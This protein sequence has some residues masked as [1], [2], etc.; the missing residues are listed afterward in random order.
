MSS[1]GRA[2]S[3]VVNGFKRPGVHLTS[4]T[5]TRKN[6]F[7][8]FEVDTE[9]LQLFN[10]NVD[11][12]IKTFKAKNLKPIMD[13]NAERIIVPRVQAN[14]TNAQSYDRWYTY[15]G[16]RRFKILKGN[17]RKSYQVLRHGKYKKYENVVFVGPKAKFGGKTGSTSVFGRNPK[18]TNAYYAPARESKKSEIAPAFR[19]ARMAYLRANQRDIT[20]LMKP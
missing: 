3:L 7:G 15:K 4:S 16:V 6:R 2:K 10:R 12:Y 20:K 18:N 13:A 17:M 9:S 19:R 5:G 8:T 14:L 11:V 1:V